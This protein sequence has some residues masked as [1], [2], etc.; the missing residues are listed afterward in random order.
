MTR[1]VELLKELHNLGVGVTL[2]PAGKV[3]VE[4]DGLVPDTLWPELK[5]HRDELAELLAQPHQPELSESWS[6]DPSAMAWPANVGD[7][8]RPDLPASELWAA[9]LLFASGD[10]AKPNGVYGRL[11][12][13]RACGAVLEWRNR[14][15]KL[16]PTLDPTERISVWATRADWDRDAA[17]WLKPKSREIVA[18]L[19]LLPVP[20]ETRR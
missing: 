7:D 17:I 3:H 16:A 11:L 12:G 6:A 19:A 4:P 20:Q 9:L 15:W 2:T 18:L 1:A 13:A 14:H 5:A 8:P 10:A